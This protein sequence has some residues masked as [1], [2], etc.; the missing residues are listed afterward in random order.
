MK[1]IFKS[2]IGLELVIPLVIVF[3]TVL[4]VTISQEPS[5]IGIVI[6]L[7][8]ILF[9]IYMFM[10]TEYKIEN[11]ELTIKCGFLYNKI[12]DIKTI[13]KIKETNNPLSSPATSLDRLEINYGKFDSII[14]SPKLKSEFINDIKR[15]NPNVE[16][17]YK[18]KQ[19]DN[20]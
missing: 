20:T 9:V 17:K 1:K 19:I 11:D 10:T 16:I 15:V 6:L 2:K 18:K 12:I 4:A 7:P 3:G 14:I 8:V 13:K 5:W